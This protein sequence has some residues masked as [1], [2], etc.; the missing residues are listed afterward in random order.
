MLRKVLTQNETAIAER[1]EELWRDAVVKYELQNVSLILQFKRD[2][3]VYR[4]GIK[5]HG[6]RAPACSYYNGGRAVIALDRDAVQNDLTKTLE[7]TLPHHIAHIVCMH[8]PHLQGDGHGI[9]WQRICKELGGTGFHN[10]GYNDHNNRPFK[11]K[12]TA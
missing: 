3:K 5:K 9:G 1:A 4:N 7:D 2:L 8:W 11:R 12:A 6:L 10:Y